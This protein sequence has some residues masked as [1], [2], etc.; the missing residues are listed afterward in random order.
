M[1]EKQLIAMWIGI[2][3]IVFMCIFPP[4]HLP[5]LKEVGVQMGLDY[6]F[7]LT[8]PELRSGLCPMINMPLLFIQCFI[9]GLITTGYIITCKYRKPDEKKSK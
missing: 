5:A 3:V 1:N 7:I 8:P 2:I 4:W 6:A 9:V